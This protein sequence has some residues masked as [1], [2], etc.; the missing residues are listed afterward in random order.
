MSYT[1]QKNGNRRSISLVLLVLAVI[2][3]AGALHWLQNRSAPAPVRATLVVLEGEAIITRA[4]AGTDPPITAGQNTTLQRGDQVT[5]GD[6][7]RARLSFGD[8]ELVEIG[9]KTQLS[10]LDLYRTAMSRA[11]VAILSLEKGQVLSKLQRKP[12][13]GTRFEIQT[14][15]ATVH[16]QHAAFQ[17]QVLEKNHIHVTVYEGTVEISMGEQT[18]QVQAGQEID[19]QLGQ[20]LSPE[21]AQGTMSV[22]LPTP[23][24]QSTP[25][26]TIQE[27]TLFPPALTP[28][29]PGDEMVLYTVQ[30]GDTLYSISRKFGIPWRTIW[31]ANKKSLPSPEL[32]RAGQQLRIPRK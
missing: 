30:P 27:K 25:T 24:S 22:E 15:P 8:S 14:L 13:Q 9:S 2:A 6:N 32:I 10:I 18:A 28:T 5:T 11:L 29:R 20:P 7:T 17:C 16:T 31:E 4:D 26:L 21:P 23:L 1:V 3:V 19:V 12:L